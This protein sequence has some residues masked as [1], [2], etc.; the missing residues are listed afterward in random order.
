MLLNRKLIYE[1]RCD[2]RLKAKAE[3]STRLTYTGLRGELEHLKIKTRLPYSIERFTKMNIEDPVP[4]YIMACE[5]GG[6]T[7]DFG[8]I[9]V[10]MLQWSPNLFFF[11]LLQRRK[12]ALYSSSLP[13]ST[14]GNV[15][16]L[17]VFVFRV[18]LFPSLL[19]PVQGCLVVVYPSFYL[20]FQQGPVIFG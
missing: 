10:V 18:S 8:T 14:E 20:R 4:F 19:L 2:E 15:V 6:L 13:T 16:L 3:G 7:C 9:Y 11:Y 1:C 17:L 5:W 12:I